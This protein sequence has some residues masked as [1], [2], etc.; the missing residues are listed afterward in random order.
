[1]LNKYMRRGI[2]LIIIGVAFVLL[3]Y[4][5]MEEELF[6][7]GWSMIIGTVAFGA[8]FLYILY[9]LIRKMDRK[10]ILD[11]RAAEPEQEKTAEK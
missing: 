11:N 5:L 4:Y 2:V 8:G 10:A 7:Y 6:K 9:S 3:G 1:M